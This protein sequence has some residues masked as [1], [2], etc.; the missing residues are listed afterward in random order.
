MPFPNIQ[1]IDPENLIGDDALNLLYASTVMEEMGLARLFEAEIEKNNVIH[2]IM[3]LKQDTLK[4]GLGCNT[5]AGSGL[6][7]TIQN[8]L[9]LYLL[10]QIKLD[11]ILKFLSQQ[12]SQVR[13]NP[14]KDADALNAFACASGTGSIKKSGSNKRT[15]SNEKQPPKTQNATDSM[16]RKTLCILP[17]TTGG[18]ISGKKVLLSEST[19][20]IEFNI[21]Q[22]C[23]PSP[24]NKFIYLVRK[25]NG[26]SIT[27]E[28]MY[29]LPASIRLE[30]VTSGNSEPDIRNPDITLIKGT[31]LTI[32]EDMKYGIVETRASFLLC[33]I[34]T[35]FCE[36]FRMR[37][38]SPDRKP[39]YDSGF[40]RICSAGNKKPDVNI[41]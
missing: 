24:K 36:I 17:D 39:A 22:K 40:F 4:D 18:C 16:R 35:G 26:K 27:D 12:P 10:V 3:K 1:D 6:S 11:N 28:F 30:K 9:M 5:G 32:K 29:A 14:E 7:S 34:D 20:K 8:I 31:G 2:V 37:M 13:D 15:G 38:F 33:I 23:I 25:Y 21:S 19:V 41:K